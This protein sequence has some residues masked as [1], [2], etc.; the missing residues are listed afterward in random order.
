MTYDLSLEI[1]A[2]DRKILFGSLD[3]AVDGEYK[4]GILVEISE[5]FVT[6]NGFSFERYTDQRAE[7]GRAFH[8][9]EL[10]SL[11]SGNGLLRPR[12]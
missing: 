12:Q 11:Q 10:L 4:C 2:T 5:T 3:G 9:A 6:Q 7:H 8:H 1:I